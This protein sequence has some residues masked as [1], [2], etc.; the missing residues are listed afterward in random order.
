M[1]KKGILVKRG[2]IFGVVLC[3][4]SGV[5]LLSLGGGYSQEENGGVIIFSRP[6]KG[7]Y[8]SH[9]EH[10]DFSCEDCH[11]G[12]FELEAGAAE[13][14]GRFTMNLMEEGE[15]CGA[16]HDGE[17]AFSVKGSCTTCHI[18]V[19]GVERLKGELE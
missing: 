10:E 16:C 14:S 17:A 13:A 18:G 15:T 1:D 6:V 5:L 3:M 12:I 4:S 7:V 8:F 19:L 2:I 9:Q 11:E